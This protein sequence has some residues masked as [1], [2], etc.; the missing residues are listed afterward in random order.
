VADSLTSLQIAQKLLEQQGEINDL[1]AQLVKVRDLHREFKIYRDCGAGYEYSVCHAC[2]ASDGF[3][4][5][6]C[7][8]GHDH[9]KCW[10]CP[11][12]RAMD[13]PAE[14]GTSPVDAKAEK[15]IAEERRET[16]SEEAPR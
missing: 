14:E 4:T 9:T 8:N 15:P 1:R 2:C 12:R 6:E 5:E 11:T 7:A 13:E 3:L 16:Q 10:P